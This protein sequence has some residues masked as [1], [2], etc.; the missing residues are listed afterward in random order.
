MSRCARCGLPTRNYNECADNDGHCYAHVE[1]DS[2]IIACRD[3][4][5]ANQA[6][7]LRSVTIKLEKAAQEVDDGYNKTA[8]GLISE[9]L[10]TLS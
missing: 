7:L 5:I 10:E 2:E 8:L 1:A 4:Q 9:V 6:S 3:R